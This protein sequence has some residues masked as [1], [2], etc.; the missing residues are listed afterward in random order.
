MN[1]PPRCQPY[2]PAVWLITL[3]LAVLLGV[4]SVARAGFAISAP[5]PRGVVEI[6]AKGAWR[7]AFAASCPAGKT[8]GSV[9]DPATS[10]VPNNVFFDLRHESYTS[11]GSEGRF[12]DGI[13]YWDSASARVTDSAAVVDRFDGNASGRWKISTTWMEC[14]LPTFPYETADNPCMRQ[15][16]ERAVTIRPSLF[17]PF[18]SLYGVVGKP[19]LTGTA[20]SFYRNAAM[21]DYRVK[22]VIQ[23]RVRQGGRLRWVTVMSRANQRFSKS[24]SNSRERHTNAFP[25]FA[26][27]RTIAGSTKLRATLTVTTVGSKP[28]MKPRTFTTKVK[29]RA[30]LKKES[31]NGGSIVIGSG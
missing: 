8:C 24:T 27:P 10:I 30:A 3:A 15:P 28:A 7:I 11:G 19:Q 12:R 9:S 21:A 20:I 6:D 1:T 14:P 23:R 29:T 31:T 18:V 25:T 4:P 2:A 5:A 16:I 22:V 13:W 26:L 17:E